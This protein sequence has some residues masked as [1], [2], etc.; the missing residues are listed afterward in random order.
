MAETDL[1]L[2]A[3]SSLRPARGSRCSIQLVEAALNT[4]HQTSRRAHNTYSC[5]P[6]RTVAWRE[7]PHRARTLAT[8]AAITRAS[9]CGDLAAAAWAGGAGGSRRIC[10]ASNTR[11]QRATHL[12][13][14]YTFLNVNMMHTVE[15]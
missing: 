13:K 6:E 7:A 11:K 2:S 12:D 14:L 10:L 5:C 3:S 1:K 9:C 4:G 15:R 8:R